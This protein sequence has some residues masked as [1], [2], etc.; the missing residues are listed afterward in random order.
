M[1]LKSRSDGKTHMIS[2]FIGVVKCSMIAFF[3]VDNYPSAS[4]PSGHSYFFI[5]IEFDKISALVRGV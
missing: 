4:K 3:S 1:A 2:M 5:A